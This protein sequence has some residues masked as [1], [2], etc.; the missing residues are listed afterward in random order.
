MST[1]KPTKV[2]ME[3]KSLVLRTHEQ[4]KDKKDQLPSDV[5]SILES[6]K[7]KFWDIKKNDAASYENKV[8]AFDLLEKVHFLLGRNFDKSWAPRQPKQGQGKGSWIAS[9]E[10]R[11]QNCNALKNYLDSPG[12]QIWNYLSA[13]EQAQILAKVWGSVKQ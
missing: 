6:L 12:M 1:E 4:Y 11:I 2:T 9:N 13:F 3:E 7:D 5:K 10:Q 8:E